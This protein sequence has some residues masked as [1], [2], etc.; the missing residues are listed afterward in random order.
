MTYPILEHY[1]RF[2]FRS[3]RFL[4]HY[5]SVYLRCE[6][7]ICD[8]KD[9]NSRCTKGCISRHK[10]EISSYKWK[11]DAVIGPLRLKREESSM[12]R[13]GENVFL[14]LIT[15]VDL[16]G[17]FCE[18]FKSTFS[19]INSNAMTELQTSRTASISIST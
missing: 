11:G 17:F 8:S 13:S 7:L 15:S 1:G 16:T 5:P 4:K 12:D 2:R 19:I 9:S 18:L 6:I 3:F 10:R 14:E